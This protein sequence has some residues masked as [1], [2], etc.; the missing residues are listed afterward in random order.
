MQVPD[1]RERNEKIKQNYK[2]NQS[3]AVVEL[4]QNSPGNIIMCKQNS[5]SVGG[6]IFAEK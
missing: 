1:C 3:A 4:L 2:S 5:V 6:A